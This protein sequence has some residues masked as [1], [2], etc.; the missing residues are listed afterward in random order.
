MNDI[1]S[2]SS[3]DSSEVSL[4][5]LQ[6]EIK[7]KEQIIQ[8]QQAKILAL[9]NT[10]F[11]DQETIRNQ[12]CLMAENRKKASMHQQKNEILETNIN[13]MNQRVSNKEEE[14]NQAQ[15]ELDR[16]KSNGIKEKLD[17]ENLMKQI[18]QAQEESL[19]TSA[20]E[21]ALIAQIHDLTQQKRTLENENLNMKHYQIDAENYQTQLEVA[22]IQI[23]QFEE[24]MAKTQ[25]EINNKEKELTEVKRVNL[26]QADK[27]KREKHTNH[28]LEKKISQLESKIKSHK[29]TQEELSTLQTK[30]VEKDNEI[31]HLRSKLHSL[32]SKI[33]HSNT[34]DKDKK[35]NKLKAKLSTLN[36]ELKSDKEK[37]LAAQTELQKYQI[38]P[39]MQADFDQNYQ[40]ILN[41]YKKLKKSKKT[42]FE[43]LYQLKLS[44]ARL[45]DDLQT[46]ERHAM[47]LKQERDDMYKKL[48]ATEGFLDECTDRMKRA[49]N[50]TTILREHM[51]N[52]NANQDEMTQLQ[53]ENL[54]LKNRMNLLEDDLI[55]YTERQR[56]NVIRPLKRRIRSKKYY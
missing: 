10:L 51:I 42:T 43:E 48:V 49:E 52:V 8:K 33:S 25:E 19:A 55:A 23:K 12:E 20:R 50:E 56:R 40:K 36:Q 28:K 6:D 30:M 18:A 3:G 22:R 24:I 54:R 17:C 29:G 4:Q 32:T 53:M 34:S 44:A 41:K 14:I 31:S 1:S 39:N 9:Q 21:A 7:E 26:A 13:H 2:L 46:A 5:T 47:T 45:E 38:N 15:T 35:I 27:L 11:A 37:L 16:L